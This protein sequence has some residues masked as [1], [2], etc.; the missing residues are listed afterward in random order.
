LDVAYIEGYINGMLFLLLDDK[1]RRLLP[2]YFIYGQSDQPRTFREYSSML[3]RVRHH[4]A[5]LREAE[6]V[7]K[8]RLGPDDVLHHTPFIG[9]ETP[10]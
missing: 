2:F 1:E 9:W 6:R 10:L 4:K 7:V 5:A 3:K 8:K